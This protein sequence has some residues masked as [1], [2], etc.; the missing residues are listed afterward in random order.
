MTAI[1]FLKNVT[2]EDQRTEP[3][4]S[5]SSLSYPVLSNASLHSKCSEKHNY[6]IFCPNYTIYWSNIFMG[7]TA[8]A[9]RD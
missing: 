6:P 4:E 2:Q 7:E 1:C 8:I 5:I 3:A 9:K